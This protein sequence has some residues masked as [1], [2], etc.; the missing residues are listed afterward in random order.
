MHHDHFTVDALDVDQSDLSGAF[1]GAD[2]LAA[3]EGHVIGQ[4]AHVST[5]NM[6]PNVRDAA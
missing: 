1:T 2:A 6:N 5:Y 3:M 4:A